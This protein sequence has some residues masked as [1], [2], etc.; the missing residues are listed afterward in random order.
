MTTEKTLE[1]LLD[2]ELE[3][4]KPN[5]TS[6]KI[7]SNELDKINHLTASDVKYE[8]YEPPES[9]WQLIK[10]IANQNELDV[11]K[12]IIGE[13]LVETTLD[14]HNEIDT[15]LEIWRD[16]RNE[17]MTSLNQ[18][19]QSSNKNLPEPPN[20]R[21]T[22]KK[23]IKFFVKQ[24]REQYKEDDRFCRQILANNHNLSVINYVL[25]TANTSSNE[26]IYQITNNR[27]TPLT[28]RSSSMTIQRPPSALNKNTGIETPL[29]SNLESLIG[30]SSRQS[31][32]R[33]RYRP[34]SRSSSLGAVNSPR[35]YTSMSSTNRNNKLDENLELMVDEDKINCMQV[36]EI[37]DH[38]RDLLQKEIDLLKQ[39][40]EFL[41]ECI[42]KE[43]DYRFESRQTLCEPTL[44][45]L[46]EE[47]KRLETNLL[48]STGKNQIKISKL[49]ESVSQTNSNRSINSPILSNR[50]TPSPPNSANSNRSLNSRIASTNSNKPIVNTNITNTK[51]SSSLVRANNLVKT[52]TSTTT[53]TVIKKEI[54]SSN[55]KS[56][57]TISSTTT[58][59]L[60]LSNLKENSENK[61]SRPNSVSSIA[62][63]IDSNISANSSSSRLTA[64]QKFRQMVL[65]SRDD[66]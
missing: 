11:I 58:N 26:D 2:E 61:L 27:Q 15:L 8:P 42:Y 33:F 59:G 56:T 18:L 55:T 53:P 36:D 45:E 54:V 16:Y 22:L 4:Y 40:I 31:R 66:L 47:R 7:E 46:K 24:M 62:S 28:K 30:N 38:L 17:T 25:N 65:E 50:I 60:K 63:S 21:E 35:P 48:S 23:E 10:S 12:S 34:V 41:Y 13:S 43:N 3:N 57:K 19:K 29:V 37:A 9:L 6:T 5:E 64:V 44:N 1:E 14:L 52:T 49:P 20:I 32:Q 39:D 51:R